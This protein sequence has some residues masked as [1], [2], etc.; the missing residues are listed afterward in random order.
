MVNKT[1]NKNV[2]DLTAKYNVDSLI[3]R[4]VRIETTPR[5]N[6]TNIP[7]ITGNSRNKS[8]LPSEA[9]AEIDIYNLVFNYIKSI[10]D[11]NKK[12][13]DKIK[14]GDKD[15]LVEKFEGGSLN[16]IPENTIIYSDNIVDIKKTLDIS[17]ILIAKQINKTG[18]DH[19]VLNF[20]GG[21]IIS[22]GICQ[23][24]AVKGNCNDGG[25]DFKEKDKN[26]E[27]WIINGS[28]FGVPCEILEK[29]GIERG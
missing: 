8:Y 22:G 1:V 27:R 14:L 4:I 28:S 13:V 7:I 18:N 5:V 26:E 19:M 20:N 12:T 2:F 15:Y 25:G 6:Y 16:S 24:N 10:D 9:V 23:T 17:G 21:G 11:N 3:K 29:A